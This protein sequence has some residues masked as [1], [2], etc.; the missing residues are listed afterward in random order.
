MKVELTKRSMMS[1]NIIYI[2]IYIVII[3]SS[4]GDGFYL[5]TFLLPCAMLYMLPLQCHAMMI[6][7]PAFYYNLYIIIILS[8]ELSFTNIIIITNEPASSEGLG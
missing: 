4:M 8:N 5:R 1:I 3:H 6:R 7:T 2:Y